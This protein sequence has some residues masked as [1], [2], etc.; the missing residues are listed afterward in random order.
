MM[1]VCMVGTFLLYYGG[2]VELSQQHTS[3]CNGSEAGATRHLKKNP[4]KG[5]NNFEQHS[6]NKTFQ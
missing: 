4:Q 1:I 3:L 5:Q 6:G 2:G